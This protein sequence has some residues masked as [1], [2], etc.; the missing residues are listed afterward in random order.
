MTTRFRLGTHSSTPGAGMIKNIRLGASMAQGG[1][2][3]SLRDIRK[4]QG[5]KSKGWA[6]QWLVYALFHHG[7][8]RD[9]LA[10]DIIK[11]TIIDAAELSVYY[12]SVMAGNAIS[13]T[14][15]IVDVARSATY[16]VPHQPLRT[17]GF[18]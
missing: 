2:D 5:N 15:H 8:V 6:M 16:P 1:E 10:W 13:R 7:P 14:M 12:S 4:L 9:S 18:W 3:A 17:V 11:I